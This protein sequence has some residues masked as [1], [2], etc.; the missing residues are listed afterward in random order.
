MK[1]SHRGSP[2]ESQ[3][4]GTFTSVAAIGLMSAQRLGKDDGDLRGPVN[5][6]TFSYHPARIASGKLR[7]R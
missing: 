4:M 7:G 5:R 2:C 1:N 3:I 6:V